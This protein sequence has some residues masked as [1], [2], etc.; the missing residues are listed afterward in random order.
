MADHVVSLSNDREA[1]LGRILTDHNAPPS[2]GQPPGTVTKD[3][4]IRSWVLAPIKARIRAEREAAKES[5]QS[6]YEALTAADKAAVDAI[7]FR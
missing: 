1:A 4:L 7:L 2:P 6:R 3:E 5:L